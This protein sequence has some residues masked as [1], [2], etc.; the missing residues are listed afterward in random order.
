MFSMNR[1]NLT[2]PQK[3]D[4]AQSQQRFV[5]HSIWPNLDNP[6]VA[7]EGYGH[8]YGWL[9]AMNPNIKIVVSLVNEIKLY[10]DSNEASLK[11]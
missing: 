11:D 10:L 2:S 4:R 8:R 1:S 9:N 7:R 3:Y 5:S 6:H